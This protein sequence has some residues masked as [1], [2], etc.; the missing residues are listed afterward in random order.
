MIDGIELLRKIKE[1]AHDDT[2][3]LLEGDSNVGGFFALNGN[4]LYMMPNNE[5]CD[6]QNIST[7]FLHLET[8]VY[9]SAFNMSVQSFKDGFYNYIELFIKEREASLENLNA[10]IMLCCS[11]ASHKEE[12]NFT[13]FFDSLVTL[14]Q[15]PQEQSYKN[16]IG[17]YGELAVIEYFF[18]NYREDLSKYWHTKGLTSKL[19]F[20]MQNLN[21]EVKTTQSDDLIFKIKHEQLFD[22]KKDTYLVAVSLVEN[23]SGITLNELANSMLLAK[24]YCNSLEFAINLEIERRRVSPKDANQKRFCLRKIRLYN[25]REICPFLTKPENVYDLSYRLNLISS[26]Q[27]DIQQVVNILRHN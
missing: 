1:C 24:D 22:N 20:V 3:Y 19:D 23:N 27:E 26:N 7:E 18:E 15:L 25:V 17:I 13:T 10:F 8:N 14:F 16:L 5:N 21:M 2:L 12:T 9:V 6:C 4:M 11:Y